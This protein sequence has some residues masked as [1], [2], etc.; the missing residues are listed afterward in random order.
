[1]KKANSETFSDRTNIQRSWE[2][3]HHIVVSPAGNMVYEFGTLRMGYDSKSDGHHEFEAVLL[4]VYM[5][6][7]NACEQVALTMQPLEP[8]KKN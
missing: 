8:Q 3:D 5:A 6:K 4:M 7:G 1:M 2:D